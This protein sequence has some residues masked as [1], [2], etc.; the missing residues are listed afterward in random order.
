[1]TRYLVT[2]GAGFIGSNLIRHLLNTGHSVCNVDALT[3]AGNLNSLSDLE[4][5]PLYSFKRLDIATGIGLSAVF[6]EFVPD[7]VLHLAAESH[8]DRSI[9][10]PGQFIQTNIVGTFHLLQASLGYYRTLSPESATKFRFLHV[11][12]D[13]VFGSLGDTG[14]FS[15][16]T[17]YDP[18]SPYSASKAASDH[19]VRAWYHTY[20]LPILVTNCSNNYG[21]YQFPEKL[22]PVVILKCIREESIPVYG[23]GENIRDWLYVL[24]HCKAI[25][26][27]VARGSIGETYT[28][29]GNNE[30]RNIDLVKKLCGIM[31][32]LRPRASGHR[33]E[34]LIT[35]VTDRPGHDVRYAIDASKLKDELGWEPDSDHDSLFR[36]TVQ[37]YLNSESWWQ[38]ILSGTY[39]LDRLGIRI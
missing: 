18:R 32:V 31:D 10:A 34:D 8:V 15:E 33:Y 4:H 30:M 26:T 5:S 1:M 39:R 29:G 25:E 12:T 36:D 28:V 38:S 3:Y 16:T 35:Y 2:G 17:P 11:S 14:Y 37:W 13:E 24:D 27:V 19:L 6:E 23:K 22:I 7:C 21:P 9:D 20:E